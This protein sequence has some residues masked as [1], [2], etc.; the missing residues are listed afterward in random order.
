MKTPDYICQ[1]E[2][3]DAPWVEGSATAR[4]T[5]ESDLFRNTLSRILSLF[6]QLVYLASLRNLNT[7]LYEHWG[8]AQIYGEDETDHALGQAHRLAFFRWLC[9]TLEQQKSDLELYV[10]GLDIDRRTIVRN[11]LNLEPYQN[12]VPTAV[13]DMEKQLYLSDFRVLLE[14][15]RNEQGIAAP[16]LLE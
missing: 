6:G 14:L 15:L 8:L 4:Q 12:L 7:G 13:Q 2:R 3:L 9:L 16:Q 1:L 10:C 11:W 5:A